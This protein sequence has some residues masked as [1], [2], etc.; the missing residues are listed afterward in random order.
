VGRCRPPSHSSVSQ[1]Y[2]HPVS[3]LRA[4]ARSGG[5]CWLM[6]GCRAG[7]GCLIVGSVVCWRWRWW[8][9]WLVVLSSPVLVCGCPVVQGPHCGQSPCHP[10][11]RGVGV[12]G[13]CSVH[14]RS[15]SSRSWAWCGCFC[16]LCCCLWV[17]CQCDVAGIEGSGV[18]LAGTSLHGPPIPSLGSFREFVIIPLFT[19]RAGARSS[20]AGVGIAVGHRA[21]FLG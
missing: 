15:T 19:L 11:Q 16:A 12:D 9:Y 5:G 6:L 21:C 17:C 20:G 1:L 7:G 10:R 8:S 4:V 14:P 3:T 2:L 18:H 13:V